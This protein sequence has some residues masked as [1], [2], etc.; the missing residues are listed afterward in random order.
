MLYCFGEHMKF[1]KKYL[2]CIIIALLVAVDRLTKEI[3]VTHLS[4]GESKP[5]I[6]GVFSFTY[7]R[8]EGM[9]WGMFAGGRYIF[10]IFTLVAVAFFFY[11][12]RNTVGEKRYAFFRALLVMLTAGAIGNMID[13]ATLGY[14]IDFLDFRLINFP[15]FNFAD[16]LVTVSMILLF[17]V[18]LFRF[19]GDDMDRIIGKKPGNDASH[20]EQEETSQASKEEDA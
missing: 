8:N 19:D 17:I 11:M 14:V 5:L 3:V 20:D 13:R 6:K 10:L 9:A 15:V 2:F 16:I 4:L 7:I 18:L 12:Y 1:I